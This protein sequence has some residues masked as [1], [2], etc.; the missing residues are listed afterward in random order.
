MH[1]DPRIMC[2]LVS[3]VQPVQIQNFQP[4]KRRQQIPYRT[5]R[6]QQPDSTV[7]HHVGQPLRRVLWI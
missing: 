2:G 5:L 1:I 4:L 7:V 6:Q 3:H